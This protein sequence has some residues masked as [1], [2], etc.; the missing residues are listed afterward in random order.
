MKPK[1]NKSSS[2]QEAVDEAVLRAGLEIKLNKIGENYLILLLD[3][4]N[5]E[6]VIRSRYP[7]VI[8]DWL[9][10]KIKQ[11]ESTTKRLN[12]NLPVH[13]HNKL[14][15]TCKRNNRKIT[16][17]IEDLVLNYVKNNL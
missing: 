12:I 2:I 3:E 1:M 7:E 16:Q 17:V 14:M 13:L 15:N 9:Y 5:W 4:G 6:E 11:A 8:M 10:G